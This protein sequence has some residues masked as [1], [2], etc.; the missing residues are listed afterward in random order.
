MT[1]QDEAELIKLL[2]R[3]IDNMR[4]INEILALIVPPALILKQNPNTFD[5]PN[6]GYN[7]N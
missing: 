6:L 4:E 2:A 3:I 5:Y 7:L 1:A